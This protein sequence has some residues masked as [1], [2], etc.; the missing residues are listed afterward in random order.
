MLAKTADEAQ[1]LT[2]TGSRL[3]PSI[4][5]KASAWREETVNHQ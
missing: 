3:Q 1:V 4:K 5:P 2:E